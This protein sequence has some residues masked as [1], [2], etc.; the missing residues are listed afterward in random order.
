MNQPVKSYQ[1]LSAIALACSL[2]ACA[3]P[4][5]H[6]AASISDRESAAV[7][8]TIEHY[9]KDGPVTG[10]DV[11]GES[12]IVFI[13]SEKYSELDDD[14]ESSMKSTLLNTWGRVWQTNHKGHAAVLHV[15][16]QN[17]YGQV[18]DTLTKRV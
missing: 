18:V 5:H 7:S 6:T 10:F 13:D 12:L 1:W 16:F 15:V 17:Y 9:K 11:K 14:V 4:Q 3:S 8:P 2:C